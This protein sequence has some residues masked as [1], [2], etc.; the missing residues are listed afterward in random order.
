MMDLEALLQV[1]RTVGSCPAGCR[2]GHNT[3]GTMFVSHPGFMDSAR[4][5]L[6]GENRRRTCT[7]IQGLLTAAAERVTDMERHR[8]LE[9]P[10]DSPERQELQQKVSQLHEALVRCSRGMSNLQTTYAT[11]PSVIAQLDV[12]SNKCTYLCNRAF[13]M[14]T[15]QG[16]QYSF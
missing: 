15:R 10:E 14:V 9:E 4:R 12:L 3:G 1:L 5:T 7:T 6:M 2:L 16:H 11:D 8:A 13:A